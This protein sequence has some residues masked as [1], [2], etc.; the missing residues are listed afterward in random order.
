MPLKTWATFYNERAKP[1][2]VY[3][4]PE[5]AD[6]TMRPGDKFELRVSSPNIELVQFEVL[7]GEDYVQIYAAGAAPRDFAIFEGNV[8]LNCGHNRELAGPDS[9]L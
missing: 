3:L 9:G 5:G 6:Y 7:Y 2:T 8:E 1:L 4:E